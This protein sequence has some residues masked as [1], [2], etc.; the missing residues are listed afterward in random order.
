MLINNQETSS[1]ASHNIFQGISTLVCLALWVDRV[2]IHHK[3]SS[4]MLYKS[5]SSITPLHVGFQKS[6]PP[7]MSI[8]VKLNSSKTMIESI[9]NL[10]KLV[11]TRY[12]RTTSFNKFW[13]TTNSFS[14][15]TS[16]KSTAYM[17]T[18]SM[19]LIR[20]LYTKILVTN[21]SISFKRQRGFQ[22]ILATHIYFYHPDFLF[23]KWVICP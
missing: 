14:I 9:L 19:R 16:N 22:L 23:L 5:P 15:D 2:Q 20:F 13:E 3:Q 10:P 21:I 8:H 11:K 17:F 18:K 12:V 1:I 6:W 4:N 7:H